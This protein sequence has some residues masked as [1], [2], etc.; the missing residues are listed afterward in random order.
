M[1]IDK[2][3]KG[4]YRFR[5]MHKG[6]NYSMTF[7]G[8]EKEAK[9]AHDEFVLDVKKGRFL[10]AS[11]MTLRELWDLY[12]ES[13][14]L[15]ASSIRLYTYCKKSFDFL[16]M[17]VQDIS[18]MF[19]KAYHNKHKRHEDDTDYR[20]LKAVLNFGVEMDIIQVN[21]LSFKLR[22]P[23]VSKFKA[24][25]T[26]DELGTLIQ[27][28]E[29]HENKTIGT[30]LLTQLYCGLRYGEAAGLTRKRIDT[31][32]HK[33]KVV[34]QYKFIA[35]TG[36]KGL[37][38][39]K[40]ESSAREVFIIKP[41]RARLYES[42]LPLN[43]DDFVFLEKKRLPVDIVEVNTALAEI[44]SRAGLPK[45]TSHKMRKLASTIALYSGI[46]PLTVSKM[47]GHTSLDMT[48]RYLTVFEEEM[49]EASDRMGG[50]VLNLSK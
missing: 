40:T 35:P 19:L 47:L 21:P 2:R 27:A 34:E 43:D 14:E 33:I 10:Q 49:A 36:G 16:D 48:E 23:K 37:G 42:I 45:M 4:V 12:L 32:N 6:S 13:R 17:Q 26:K 22:K 31:V 46:D 29:N 41:L 44:T 1:S 7:Y 5:V 9:R 38:K 11:D 20:V 25:L 15:E 18:K 24:L 39:L 50:F 3:G 28:I 8:S 30:L